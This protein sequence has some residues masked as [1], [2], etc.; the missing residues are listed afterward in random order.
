MNILLPTRAHLNFHQQFASSSFGTGDGKDVVDPLVPVSVAPVV[1]Q[2][3]RAHSVLG[4][5]F[6]Y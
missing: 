6:R 5:Q 2:L 1:L 4:R 3:V